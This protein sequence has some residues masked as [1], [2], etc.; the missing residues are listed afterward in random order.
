[1]WIFMNDAML[2]I[3]QYSVRDTFNLMVRARVKGDIERVFPRA[4]V[5]TGKGTD[6]QF[7]AIVSRRV[8]AAK[9]VE[10]ITDIDYAN[11]K[12]SVRD[13]DRHD[14]YLRVWETM[15][16]Y[17]RAEMDKRRGRGPKQKPLPFFG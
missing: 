16:A 2:S 15:V 4:K 5:I 13:D 11:F 10:R 9:M 14:A 12:N 8:V 3:V 1:M 17:Q 6:Y 7:R